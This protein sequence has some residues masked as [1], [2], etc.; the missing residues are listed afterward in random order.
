MKNKLKFLSLAFILSISGQLSCQEKL[1][2]SGC[3]NHDLRIIDKNTKKVVWKHELAANE[4]CNDAELNKK[5]Q[6]LYAYKKGARLISKESQSVIWDFKAL[7]QEEVFTATQLRSGNYMVAI[8]GNPS[9]IVE[10]N[11]KGDSVFVLRFDTGIKSVHGQFRQVLHTPQ[12]T[13]LIPLMASGQVIEMNN[14][15]KVLKRIQVGGNPYSVKIIKGGNWLVSC[16]DGHSIVEVNPK[17]IEEVKIINNSSLT[18]V[19]LLF[20][21]E[22]NRDSFGNT[23]ICNWEGH[24]NDTT[25][26][27]IFEV[28]KNNKVIWGIKDGNVA[29]HISTLYILKK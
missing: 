17:K 5:G 13:Y 19:K 2:V 23:L 1:L 7:P 21:S 26:Y 16:G 18:D 25:Q 9:R 14:K 3:G 28:D 22:L 4:E 11:S 6:V 15:G 29:N 24:A 10:L 8:C 20:V 12:G 27:K